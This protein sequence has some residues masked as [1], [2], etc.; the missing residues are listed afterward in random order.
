MS[1]IRFIEKAWLY[2]LYELNNTVQKPKLFNTILKCLI[3]S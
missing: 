2:K 3:L 1:L